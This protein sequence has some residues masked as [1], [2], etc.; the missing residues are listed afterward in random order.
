MNDW[1]IYDNEKDWNIETIRMLNLGHFG[2]VD[3]LTRFNA[4]GE[5]E[6]L[7]RRAEIESVHIDVKVEEKEDGDYR[8]ILIPSEVDGEV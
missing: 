6:Y 4:D 3:R 1:K 8:L 7:V 5:K 2:S